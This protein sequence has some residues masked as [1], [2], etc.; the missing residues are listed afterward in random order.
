[1]YDAGKPGESAELVRTSSRQRH[2]LKTPYFLC[3]WRILVLSNKEI[4]EIVK[5]TYHNRN[6]KAT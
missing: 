1:M 3:N 4:Y 2:N 5:K 6:N